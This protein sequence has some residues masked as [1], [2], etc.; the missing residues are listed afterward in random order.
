MYQ[1]PNQQNWGQQPPMQQVNQM[2][3]PAAPAE[4][5]EEDDQ[6]RRPPNAFILFSQ[7]MRSQIRSENPTL[8]NTEV[9][10]I[11]GKMWK[12][13]PNDQKVQY[14][15]KAAQMQEDFKKS[16]PDYTYR[17]ARRKR[18]L[19]ELLTKS[20]NMANPGE[21]YMMLGN[22]MMQYQP[23]MANQPPMYNQQMQYGYVPQMPG[24]PQMPQQSP[25]QGQ[26]QM[27]QMTTM[28]P[29][30]QMHQMM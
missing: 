5:P 27:Q 15:Q 23:M 2:I 11:L 29:H 21:Q 25:M 6:S 12:E 3:P 18:A 19:N 9:S 16:H 1:Q 17:K 26:P 22:P 7:V 4:Q 30:M 20:A 28:P 13:V 8:S 24:N 14:K 10:R